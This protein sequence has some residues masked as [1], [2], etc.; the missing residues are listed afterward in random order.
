MT[1]LNK[2][3]K[4]HSAN[5]NYL[6]PKSDISTSFGMCHFAGVVVYETKGFLEKNRD[7]FS[8]DLIQL[9]QMSENRFMQNLFISEVSMVRKH[10]NKKPALADR[11]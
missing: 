6:K 3:H 2:L 4:Q 7:T 11:F 8:A 5:R 1:L 9:I 10:N